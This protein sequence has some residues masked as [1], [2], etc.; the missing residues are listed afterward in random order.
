VN[1]VAALHS[2]LLRDKVLPDFSEYWPEKFTNVTN[3]VTP[4]RFIRLANPGLS[5]LITEAIGVGWLTDL[6]RLN[7]LE[8]YAEDPDFRAAFAGVKA[9]NKT[10]FFDLLRA[11]DGIDLPEDHLIDV[12]VKRLHEYKRQSLKVLH[13][14]T[15]YEQIISGKVRPPPATGS[16][17]R[18]ST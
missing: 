3:G 10:R 12:M 16:R 15:L 14:V 11:R 6:E 5:Q 8:P 7:E 18:P 17:R 4:R 13:I 2:Q 1:G 9:N